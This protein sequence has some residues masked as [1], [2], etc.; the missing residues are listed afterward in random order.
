MAE[1]PTNPAPDQ[2]VRLFLANERRLMAFALSLLP[3][4][5]EAE[6]VLAEATSVMWQKFNDFDAAAPDANFTAWAFRI[7]RFKVMEHQRSRSRDRHVF[8]ENLLDRLAADAESM[9][10]RTESRFRALTD[11]V[12][13]LPSGERELVMQRYRPGANVQAI[14]DAAGKSTVTIRNWLRRIHGVLERCI[15][16]NISSEGFT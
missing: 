2:F 1:T 14:A 8:D 7:I 15:H 11:C 16:D 10:G 6:E 3:D 5:V 4:F 9:T 13:K 12:N